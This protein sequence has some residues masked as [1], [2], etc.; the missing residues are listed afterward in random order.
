MKFLA[1]RMLG[2]LAKWLRILGYDT[3]LEGRPDMEANLEELEKEDEPRV[4]L[5]R[6]RK[7]PGPSQAYLLHSDDPMEQLKEVV[8]TF[9]LTV[10]EAGIFSRCS[11]CNRA[12]VAVS[13]AEVVGQVPDYVLAGHGTFHRCPRCGR[14]YWPGSHLDRMK[15]WLAGV[16][17]DDAENSLTSSK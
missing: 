16:L 6:R 1:E 9:R 7:K 8:V 5:T 13:R 3:V 11:V 17:E 15:K 4:I 2:R 10:D 12:L 14:V